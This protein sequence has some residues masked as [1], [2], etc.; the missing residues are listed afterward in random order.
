MPTL[1]ATAGTPSTAAVSAA[2]TVP[3]CSTRWP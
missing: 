1:T 3:E 2:P